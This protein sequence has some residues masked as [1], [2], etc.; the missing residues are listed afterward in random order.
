MQLFYIQ[1][2]IGYFRLNNRSNALCTF[3]KAIRYL[4]SY[5]PSIHRMF[6]TLY[7]IQG[8]YLMQN[9]QPSEAIICLKKSL[10]NPYY[11][12][13]QEF[14]GLI[15]SLLASACVQ[16]GDLDTAELYCRKALKYP[17]IGIVSQQIPILLDSIGV[18]HKGRP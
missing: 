10:D 6:A 8:Y 3:D 2:A 17:S 15:N 13:N 12:T 11:T 4:E 18:I 5:Y 9:N 16:C 14:C 1:M 7:F